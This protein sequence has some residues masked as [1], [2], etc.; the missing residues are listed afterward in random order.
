MSLIIGIDVGGSTTKIVGVRDGNN[1]PELMTPQYVTANDP[2]TA[3]Y[4]AFGKFTLEN[5]L[6]ISDITGVMMTGV[7]SSYIKKD[8]YGLECSR[9]DEFTGIG[10]GG[11]YLSGLSEALIVSMGT[12]T[13]L[14]HAKAGGPMTYLGG[15]GVGG[16]SLMGLSKLLLKA[17]TVNHIAEFAEDGDLGNIDLRIKDITASDALE[18]L[19]GDLTAANFGNV[20]DVATKSDI[21]LGVMNMVFETVAM[22]SV[23][24]ARSV[25][26]SNIVLTGN[27]TQLDYCHRKFREMNGMGYGVTFT[28][29]EH[30]R[31]S[32]VIGAAMCG[33]KKYGDC[34]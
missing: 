1:G 4:G 11:L 23:F 9:I 27:V 2:I 5:G 30:S 18:S 24:A 29:P 34:R 6:N 14:V 3:T 28:I 10:V 16:G 15:T 7:G 17:E 25:G 33:L 19:S 26:V 13:A 12:G 22:V 20:S 32:T 21:A 31:F 8:L